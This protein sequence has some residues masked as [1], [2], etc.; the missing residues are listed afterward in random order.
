MI[1]P[2]LGL[3]SSL[4]CR[5]GEAV[6]TPL[7]I[8]CVPGGSGQEGWGGGRR[9]EGKEAVA[10]LALLLCLCHQAHVEQGGGKDLRAQGGPSGSIK[11]GNGEA[12]TRWDEQRAVPWS[13]E[14]PACCG[15]R[16]RPPVLGRG[17]SPSLDLTD[18]RRPALGACDT[19]FV[20]V[21]LAR[22][23]RATADSTQTAGFILSQFWGWRPEEV[24]FIPAEALRGTCPGFSPFPRR[25]WWTSGI[26]MHQWLPLT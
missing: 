14:L 26:P 22:G 13:L 21:L 19:G 17:R 6:P 16:A 20:H 10:G 4:G 2:G 11:A 23:S 9:R 18:P 15:P 24:R 8:C 5:G 7:H 3:D 25:C 1:L 12:E